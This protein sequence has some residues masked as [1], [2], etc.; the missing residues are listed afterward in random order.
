MDILQLADIV[1]SRLPESSVLP[2]HRR[3]SLRGGEGRG[4]EGRGGQGREGE[5]REGEAHCNHT[6][7]IQGVI[8]TASFLV[9]PWLVDLPHSV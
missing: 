2:L 7:S 8:V 9:K 1:E 6:W 4:G 5:G 3:I